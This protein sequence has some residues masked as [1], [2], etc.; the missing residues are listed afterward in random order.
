MAVSGSPYVALGVVIRLAAS[1]PYLAKRTQL[2]RC[3]PSQFRHDT[4]FLLAIALQAKQAAL[5]R[6]DVFEAAER[7]LAE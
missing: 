7:K 5:P 2:K 3:W 4:R 1:E 6:V